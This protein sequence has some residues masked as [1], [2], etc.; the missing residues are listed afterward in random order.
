MATLRRVFKLKKNSGHYELSV[1]ALEPYAEVSE[2]GLTTLDLETRSLLQALYFVAHGVQV[3]ADHLARGIA[4]QTRNADGSPFDWAPTLDGLFLV[5]SRPGDCGDEGAHVSVPY[6][7]HCFFID[8]TDQ[9][10]KS[11]FALLME[12]ARLQFPGQSGHAP[13]LT[14]PIGGR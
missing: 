2:E 9:D 8:E 10:T 12:L 7:G 4:R 11:T 13:M 3:P 14:I 6:Q 5:K 1:E